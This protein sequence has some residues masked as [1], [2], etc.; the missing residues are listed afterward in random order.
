MA[1]ANADAK[2]TLVLGYEDNLWESLDDRL[3]GKVG[4]GRLKGLVSEVVALGC[5]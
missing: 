2:T 3:V 5:E 4:E 1:T